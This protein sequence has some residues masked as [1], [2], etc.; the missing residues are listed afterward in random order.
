MDVKISKSSCQ[1]WLQLSSYKTKVSTKI[2]KFLMFYQKFHKI[3][4][5]FRKTRLLTI[6]SKKYDFEQKVENFREK[7][8]DY[9]NKEPH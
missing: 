3:R 9:W 1:L 5:K 4:L 2:Q 8:L 6:F 7:Y